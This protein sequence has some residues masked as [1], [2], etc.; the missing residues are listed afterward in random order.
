MP[1]ATPYGNNQSPSPGAA[2]RP[3]L[4]TL[5][6]TLLPTPVVTDATG[7][8]NRTA[9]RSPNAKKHAVGTTLTDALCGVS[10]NPRFAVGKPSSADPPPHQQSL[11][12]EVDND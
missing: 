4:D 11:D 2:V 5:A 7:T 10:T 3:S 6:M 1:T 9:G 12:P 8:R